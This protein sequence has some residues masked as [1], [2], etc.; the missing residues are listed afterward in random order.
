[1]ASNSPAR[2]PIESQQAH[3]VVLSILIYIP[4]LPAPSQQCACIKAIERSIP[5]GSAMI[6]VLQALLCKE[7]SI[8]L[9]RVQAGPFGVN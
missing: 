6:G 9:D 8:C 1:M 7:L 3:A 5:S 2:D 4:P